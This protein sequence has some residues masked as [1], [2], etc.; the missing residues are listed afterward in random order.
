M[1]FKEA[2]KYFSEMGGFGEL[3]PNIMSWTA[4][5]TGNLQNGYPYQA[6]NLFKKMVIRG[7]KPNST[8]ISSVISA[9]AYLSLERN[10]KE[11]HGYCIKSEEIDSN[12]FVG[13]SL[14]SFYSKSQRLSDV[15]IKYFDRTKKG[16]L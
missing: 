9:C 7:V 12:L 6:L 10:G 5:I 2:A 16:R 1:M 15:A 3:E 13:N 8:T 14:I 11:I 4:L